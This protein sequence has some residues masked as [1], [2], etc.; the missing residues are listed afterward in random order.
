[1]AQFIVRQLE[2][3]IK[4]RLKRRAEHNGR[5]MEAEAREILRAAVLPQGRLI[6]KLGSRIAARFQSAG[7]PGE[8]P[9]LR[10]ER[11]RPADFVK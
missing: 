11:A 8:L 7:L 9:E 2:E 4:V 10:G 5:S 1:M 3:D 6:A